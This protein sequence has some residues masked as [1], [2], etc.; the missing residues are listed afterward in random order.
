MYKADLVQGTL[1][2]PDNEVTPTP[3][4]EIRPPKFDS[5]LRQWSLSAWDPATYGPG[6]SSRQELVT[7][8]CVLKQ[9]QSQQRQTFMHPTPLSTCCWCISHRNSNQM[10][11]LSRE[12]SGGERTGRGGRDGNETAET[13]DTSA[14]L[15]GLP[16]CCFEPALP[17]LIARCHA[18]G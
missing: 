10:N 16:S 6:R 8:R 4:G 5:A 1:Q 11:R 15:P 14:A 18:G 3:R 12:S 17:P 7:N 2:G 9:P 13:D